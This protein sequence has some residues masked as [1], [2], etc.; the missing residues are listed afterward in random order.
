MAAGSERPMGDMHMVRVEA[1]LPGW[2]YRAGYVWR[3]LETSVPLERNGAFPVKG[4]MHSRL[5]L[6]GRH[7]ARMVVH[8]AFP[9]LVV[10]LVA[11]GIAHVVVVF[12]AGMAFG[13][14]DTIAVVVVAE[15]DVPAVV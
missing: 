6:I 9:V 7:W 15:V 10:E 1:D 12:V 2:V 3:L 11:A 14:R 8:Y 5:S 4:G 13:A